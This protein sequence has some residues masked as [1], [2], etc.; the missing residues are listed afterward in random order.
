MTR[1][2]FFLAAATTFF[3]VALPTFTPVHADYVDAVMA[4]DPVAYWRLSEDSGHK[5]LD[6]ANRHNGLYRGGFALG[7]EGVLEGDTAAQFGTRKP[8]YAMIKHRNDFLLDEG[9]ISL[10]FKDTGSIN[11]AGLFS[12][13]SSGYDTGGHLAVMIDDGRVK[14]RLQSTTHSYTVKSN[15][16]ELDAWYNLTFTFGG[17]GMKLYMDGSLVD[18]DAYAG[19]LGASSGGIGNYKPLALGAKTWTS[20]NR[21]V[22]PRTDYF[23]GL[24]DEV[25]VFDCALAASDVQDL[26]DAHVPEPVTVMLMAAGALALARRSQW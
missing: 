25:A 5:L 20:G 16:I 17:E 10:W 12:K 24:L 1:Q 19:G 23:S 3:L 26:Y 2:R 22:T 11:N 15:P 21:T 8:G 18:T 7:Q 14:A 4:R 9:A 13:D 6:L